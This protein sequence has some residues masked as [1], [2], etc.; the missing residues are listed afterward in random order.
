MSRIGKKPIKIPDKVE[1]EIKDND[2]SIKGPL[3]TLSLVVPDIL[4]I[5]KEDND[6]VLDIIKK[7]AESKAFWGLF[8]ALVANIVIGVS[9]G[10]KKTL[11][12]EGV[13]YKAEVRGKELVLNLGYS[14][15]I[16]M[17]IPEGLSVQ[18]DKSKIN[19]SGIDKQLVGQFTANIRKNRKPEPYKG[20][21]IRYEGERVRRKAGKRAATGPGS[22]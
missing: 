16:I 1:V 19:I 9:E 12:I 2:V 18:V 17:E 13:G 11:E 3:G 15:P 20:K 22:A 5:K 8:R 7:K 4:S 10:F 14:H 6:I 21:G